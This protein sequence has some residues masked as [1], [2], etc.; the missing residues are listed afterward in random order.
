MVKKQSSFSYKKMCETQQGSGDSASIIIELVGV[1][2][3]DV[4]LLVW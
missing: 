1:L 3:V 2:T 4:I